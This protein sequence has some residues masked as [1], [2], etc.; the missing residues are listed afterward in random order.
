MAK[1][2]NIHLWVPEL[3]CSKGGIQVF[4]SFLMQAIH[5]LY[6]HAKLSVLLKND[7]LI[8]SQI[9][10]Q[11][12]DRFLN[13][14]INVQTNIQTY[15]SGKVKSPFRTVFFGLRLLSLAIAQKP[16]L[17]IMTHLNFAPIALILQKLIGT[18]Y[19]AIAHGVEAWNIQN[20]LLKRS[21]QSADLIL[22][23]SN[24]T[25]D[26]L[27]QE[28]NL[29]ADQVRILHNT[30]DAQAWKIAPKPQYLLKKY[31]LSADQKIILTV[32]RLS[33]TEQY[34]GYDRLLEIMPIIRQSI[35]NIHYIIV[36][37][38]DDRDRL[39][40]II[41]Q[42]NLQSCVTLAGF[43]ADEYLCDYYNLCDLFAMPSK[44]EGFGIVYLEALACGKP[45]LGGNLDGTVDALCR[46]EIGV[47]INPDNLD[48]IAEAIIQILSG[49]HENQAIYQPEFLRQQAIATFGFE[50][51][52]KTLSN[53][54]SRF[55]D[56]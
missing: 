17:V 48:E 55:L 51:F 27:C 5:S 10:E 15:C 6:P 45:V 41:N 18:K 49:Q 36:G 42:N 44:A 26:R 16:S 53:H 37:K 20:P 1:V 32:S 29:L 40:Q 3:F 52:Q 25:R 54:L 2:T 21:L 7:S 56:K 33:A 4:S 35:P 14:H 12:D 13:I 47:L 43:V 38:G 22:A 23:V 31:G 9:V 24:F 46:G 11:D 19:I 28:Q 34:K 50:H 8:V 30:F 39:E